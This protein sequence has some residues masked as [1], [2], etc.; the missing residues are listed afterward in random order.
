MTSK[1]HALSL[2]YVPSHNRLLTLPF[3][4]FVASIIIPSIVIFIHLF[5]YMRGKKIKENDL[6]WV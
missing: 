6:V 1:S 4:L 5:K 2:P 3:F